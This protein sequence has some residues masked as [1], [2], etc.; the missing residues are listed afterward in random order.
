[1]HFFSLHVPDFP[2]QVPVC[3]LPL[4]MSFP[5]LQLQ[6]P[7]MSLTLNPSGLTCKWREW[8]EWATLQRQQKQRGQKDKTGQWHWNC[9]RVFG[10]ET[11]YSLEK[12]QMTTL[13]WLAVEWR[14]QRPGQIVTL[15]F[16]TLLI[17]YFGTETMWE[18]LASRHLSERNRHAP[19][20][21]GGEP[22]YSNI[23]SLSRV[24][25]ADTQTKDKTKYVVVPVIGMNSTAWHAAHMHGENEHRQNLSRWKK[26]NTFWHF[27]K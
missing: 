16:T 6:S 4:P 27:G 1:M 3:P 13:Q 2:W 10:L 22:L 19:E 11:E 9:R 20:A 21:G 12:R 7:L 8:M 15:D 24:E 17:K 14:L 23:R 25:D 18:Q 5:L 26:T